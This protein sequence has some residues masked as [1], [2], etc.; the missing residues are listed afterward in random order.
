MTEA[1]IRY[2]ICPRNPGAHLFE[3]HC[4]VPVPDPAG[5]RVGLPAWIPGSYMIRDFARNVVRLWAHSQGESVVVRKTGKD[6]WVCASCS[7]PLTLS[8]EV[9]AWDLSVR[10]AHL[11]TTHAYFNGTSVFLQ[12]YGRE[13]DPCIVDIDPPPPGTGEGWRV[14]T[15]LN[16]AQAEPH[17]FGSYGARDYD[18][19][20]D[21]PVE[22]GH[23]SLAVFDACG[24]S[25]EIAVSGRHR[26]DL[27]RLCR[28]LK[29]VCEHHIRFFG[30]PAPMDR[31]VFLIAAVGEGYGGLEHRA[32][33]SLLCQRDTLPQAGDVEVGSDYRSF[34]G[35]ASH[36]YFHAWNVK[37]IKPQ[38][39][40]GGDL[41]R[42]MHTRMLWAF[43]GI[44][45]YYDDLALVRSGLITPLAYL[46][47]LGQTA[48]RVWRGSGR[49]KQ[50]L[51]DSSFDAWTKFYRQDENAPNSIV[52]YYT[53]GALVALALDLIIRRATADAR[54]LDDVM[55]LLWQRYGR[56]GIGVPEDGVERAAGE[57]AGVDLGDFFKRTVHGTDDPPLADVLADVGV[58]FV[59]RPAQSNGDSGGKPAPGGEGR[60]GPRPVLGVRLGSG[61]EVRLAQVF[62]GGAAQEAGL[63]AGDVI[64]AVDG[65]RVTS[66]NLEKSLNSRVP[67][68]RV[69]VHAFRRDELMEFDVTLKEAPA[70]TCALVLRADA[71]AAACARRNAWLQ[72]VPP[73]AGQ[74]AHAVGGG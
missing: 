50:S 14:A 71:D 52:S 38:A 8:Y 17:G 35:L 74:V 34:L 18:E 30:E 3:V 16:R 1:A 4:T 41:S 12:V 40:S 70:D 22:I 49:F 6:S 36:E 23:F 67:G 9:Y 59:L 72:G 51:A 62:D 42:E 2:R 7:G 11:D 32:S 56:P 28:D 68:N 63:A 57:I 43:E 25:H 73:Q 5:Q 64:I 13:H 45:S 37:R 31:Y 10:S 61:A 20:I 46:E 55:R 69:H 66:A 58:D 65:L 15:A 24:V 60:Q 53:K 21:H 19:L 47:L 29:R 48:T 26:A 33:A 27:E 54:S 44:T 39:F